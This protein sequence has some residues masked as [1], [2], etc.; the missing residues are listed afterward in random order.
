MKKVFLLC[1]IFVLSAKMNAQ[2]TA[3]EKATKAKTI[4]EKAVKTKAQ[5]AKETKEKEKTNMLCSSQ[6]SQLFS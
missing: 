6:F 4:T 3:K 2:E 1:L 5:T